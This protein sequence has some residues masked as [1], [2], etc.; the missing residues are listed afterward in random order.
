[1]RSDGPYAL[2]AAPEAVYLVGAAAGALGGDE[3]CLDLDV[4]HGATLTVRSVAS[5][6][7]LPGEG[8]S[9]AWVKARVAS[10]AHLDFA[11]EPAVATAGCRHHAIADLALEGDATLR[12]REELVLGRHG[13]TAGPCTSRIDVTLDG[14]PLLRHE[15]PLPD[16]A[17][18]TSSAVLGDARCTG[19]VL[20]VGPDLA[21]DAYAADG[22]AV[23]PLAGPGVLV[24]ALAP[25][26]AIL[27]QRLVQGE[28]HARG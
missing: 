23:M 26:S 9:Q 28:K 6:L 22:L 16:P 3:L 21:R 8:E 14:V 4:S 24:T 18:Y 12:W 20:L 25:D 13:E 1:M 17:F 10:G 19:D 5:A 27:R 7:L 11:L 15:L 2:R